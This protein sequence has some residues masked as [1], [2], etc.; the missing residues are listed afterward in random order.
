MLLP[1]L[2]GRG[3]S[4]EQDL[5]ACIG[6]YLSTAPGRTSGLHATG[7]L[8]GMKSVAFPVLQCVT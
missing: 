1:S 5:G 4:S 6:C 3:A 8:F 2:G 7:K